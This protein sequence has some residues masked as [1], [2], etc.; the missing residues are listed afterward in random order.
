LRY[1]VADISAAAR[2]LDYAPTRSLEA[3][4]PA[5]VAEISSR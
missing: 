5:V 3:D 2:A 1:S 4:L